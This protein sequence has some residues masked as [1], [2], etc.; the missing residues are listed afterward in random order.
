M[1][2]YTDLIQES[3]KFYYLKVNN[4]KLDTLSNYGSEVVTVF[5]EFI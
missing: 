2:S 3:Q 4:Q 5:P 1:Q